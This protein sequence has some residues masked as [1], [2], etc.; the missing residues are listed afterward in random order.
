MRERARALDGLRGSAVLLMCFSG[1]LPAALPNVMYHGYYPAYLPNEAGVFEAVPK[2]FTNQWPA[3]TWVD[4]VFPMFLFSMGAAIPLALRDKTW[5]Q[6]VPQVLGRWVLLMLFA[7][8]V[9]K[10][11]P[12]QIAAEGMARHWLAL[13]ALLPATAVFVRLP[14][15]TKSWQRYTVRTV[16]F[17]A[18]VVMVAVF[19]R[20]DAPPLQHLDIIILL[21]AHMYAVSVL[22]WLATKRRPVVRLLAALPIMLLAH[23][24]AIGVPEWRTFGNTFDPITPG[25]GWLRLGNGWLEWQ[26]LW[27]V[28]WYKFLWLVLPATLVGDWLVAHKPPAKTTRDWLTIALILA[29]VVIVLLGLRHYEHGGVLRTPWVS[30]IT[31]P[32]LLLAWRRMHDPLLR[33]IGAFA[34]VTLGLGLTLAVLPAHG[35]WFEGG[36]KKGPPATLSY[37]LTTLGLSAA[38]L[39]G[40]IVWMDVRK[41]PGF[42]IAAYVGQNALLAYMAITNLLGPVV[43]LTGVDAWT[44]SFSRWIKFGWACFKTIAFGA[45]IALLTRLRIVWKV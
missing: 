2:A 42:G 35:S 4:W 15:A 13:L 40:L 18:A 28:T 8:Y 32:L 1:I 27:D 39:G 24:Q 38:A 14:K 5:R 9:G 30:L 17:A 21:L 43:A 31:L 33:R 22:L 20:G 36:I 41:W 34:L 26:R 29:S 7:V 44:A 19:D 11:V 37:Y 45:I 6:A 25:N 16:G 12:G 3:L 23:H 10:M